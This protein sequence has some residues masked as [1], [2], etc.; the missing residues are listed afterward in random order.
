MAKSTASR[1]LDVGTLLLCIVAAT[2]FWL[3]NALN[4]DGYSLR[5][6]YPLQVS[7]NDTLYT[8]TS[9]LPRRVMV[10]I[11]GNG[12]KLLR[13]SLSFT[14]SPLVYP[15]SQPLTA[16][17][18]NTSSITDLMS[19]QV[20]DVKVNYVVA[21]TLDLHFERKVTKTVRL[22]IDSLH[23][24]LRR[25]FVISSLINLTPRTVTFEGPESVLNAFGDTLLVVVP[26]RKI[27]TDYDAKIPLDYPKSAFVKASHEQAQVSF[28]VAVLQVPL[29]S[30]RPQPAAKKAPAAKRK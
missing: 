24:D 12:W 5:V 22:K 6:A 7:Y 28:E 30:L 14:V 20:K 1:R 9:P 19:E 10:N 13:K 21:D 17:F 2:V 8:P 4:K 18:L 3:M 29:S 15:I 16:K 26:E 11:S 25:P 23:I 27:D